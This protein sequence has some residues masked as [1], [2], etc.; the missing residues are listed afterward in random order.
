MAGYL[1]LAE[2]AIYK[3][4]KT[5]ILNIYN[6]LFAV[7]MPAE[8]RF[9]MAVMCGPKWTVGDHNLKIKVKANEDGEEKQ[10]VDTTIK[11]PHEQFVYHAVANDIKFTMNYDVRYLTFTVFDNDEEVISRVYPVRAMLYPNQ[12]LQQAQAERTQEATKEEDKK[13]K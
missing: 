6:E 7:A 11:I 3:E 1:E 4:G 8:F 10:L 12:Q 9:D 2:A 13:E 5:Y